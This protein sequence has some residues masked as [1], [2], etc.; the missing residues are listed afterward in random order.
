MEVL[1]PGQIFFSPIDTAA[2]SIWVD[3]PWFRQNEG[4]IKLRRENACAADRHEIKAAYSGV[5]G[6]QI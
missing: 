5:L 1:A 4:K 6:F 3:E 2:T